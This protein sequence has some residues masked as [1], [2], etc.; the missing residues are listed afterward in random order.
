MKKLV[1]IS[2]AVATLAL[3]APAVAQVR[4]EAGPGGVE[5]GVGGHRHHHWREGY[6]YTNCRYERT[7]VTTPSGRVIIKKRRI[8]G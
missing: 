6:A 3:A 7:E 4:V 8:C 2:A 5:V 1:F